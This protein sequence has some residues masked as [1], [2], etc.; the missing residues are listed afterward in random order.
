M[1]GPGSG[2]LVRGEQRLFSQW[3]EWHAFTC[4]GAKTG[5][6]LCPCHFPAQGH[7]RRQSHY[8]EMPMFG[9]GTLQ[10]SNNQCDVGLSRGS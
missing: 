9:E 3:G 1:R 6:I 2:G 5:T 4:L 8:N 7:P 10:T